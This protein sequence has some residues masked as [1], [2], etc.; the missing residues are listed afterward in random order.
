M[1][2]VLETGI[3]IYPER[4]ISDVKYKLIFAQELNAL[5][6]PKLTTT[7]LKAMVEE[8]KRRAFP[9]FGDAMRGRRFVDKIIRGGLK[10][11]SKGI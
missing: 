5:N 6:I 9:V 7:A 3:V 1:Y 2:V 8:A 10:I 11:I 4:I